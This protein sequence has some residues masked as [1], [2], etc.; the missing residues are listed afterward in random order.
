ML[1]TDILIIRSLLSKMN[2]IFLSQLVR[3][4]LGAPPPP[5]TARFAL[6]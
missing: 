1:L 3:V 5:V 4:R 6:M 2:T